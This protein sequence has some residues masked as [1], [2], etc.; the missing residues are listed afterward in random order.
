MTSLSGAPVEGT[1]PCNGSLW[2]AEI[3]VSTH[4][5]GGT[6]VVLSIK[7][8]GGL[9]W[10]RSGLEMFYNPGY[11]DTLFVNNLVAWRVESRLALN[12]PR[13]RAVCLVTGL[14]ST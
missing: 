4:V 9:V 13:P 2:G 14:P 7:G 3:A 6:A 8:D 10:I 1:R 11:G 5:P 12:V